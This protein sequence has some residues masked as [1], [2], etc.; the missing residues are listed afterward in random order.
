[1]SPSAQE[2]E[3]EIEESRAR[4]D[5]TIDRMQDRLSVSGIADDL[6]GTVREA[7]FGS[8]FDTALDVVRRNPL[9][10][11][12][13]AAGASWLAWRMAQE[14]RRPRA[15]FD[16]VPTGEEIP[17]LSRGEARVNDPD[18]SP[19]PPTQDLAETP[20]EISTS[21]RAQAASTRSGP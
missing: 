20:G 11:L 6:M 14:V 5:L 19:R 2:L 17:V 15:R 9:P 13:I 4:L 8:V 16:S 3:Q 18:L 10:V 1:M 12:L 7:E 21:A